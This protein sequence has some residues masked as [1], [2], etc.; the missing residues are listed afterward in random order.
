MCSATA[1]P[2][3]AL[4]LTHSPVFAGWVGAASTAP[5]LLMYLPAGWFVDRFDR[6][7]L[8]FVSQGGRLAVLTLL[9]C[10]LGFGWQVAALLLIAAALGEGIFRV[11]YSAAEITAVQ[12]VVNSAELPSA[13]ARNEA[14]SHL[15]LLTGK[16]LGGFLFGCNKAFPYHISLLTIIWSI[17][18]LSAMDKKDYQP[19]S[20]DELSAGIP[21]NPKVSI[22]SGVRIVILSPFLRTVVVVCAVGNFFFQTV[23]LSLI[24]LAEQQHMSSAKIGLLLATSGLG[25][26]AGSIAAPKV[27]KW[28]RDE[29]TIVT[30]CAAAW[31][32]LTL[33]VAVSAQPVTGLIAWGGLSVTGAFLNVALI[34]HQ[35]RRVPEYMLGR[36]MGIVRLLTSGA[37][38]LGALSAGYLVAELQPHVAAALVCVAMVAMACAVP[39]LLRPRRVL[40]DTV[41]DRLKERLTPAV[42]T[43]PPSPEEMHGATPEAVP[44]R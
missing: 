20:A 6:R 37:V 23:V 21:E 1:N 17:I 28:M 29:W 44:V 22:F 5:A 39:F 4:L 8:M 24:V 30:S 12:R 41:V 10:A 33:V 34:T 43:S 32:A 42:V 7:R 16:P 13:L 36:V 11:L 40:S 26:L 35:T 9:I 25:G 18:A 14:R 3:L 38:P 15:A 31:A 2:L 27:G 19:R